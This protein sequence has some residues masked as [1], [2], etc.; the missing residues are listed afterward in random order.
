M[1]PVGQD[2]DEITIQPTILI[3]ESCQNT[4]RHL[5]KYSRKDLQ[6]EDGDVKDKVKPRKSIKTFAISRG[7]SV[8]Q[9]RATSN[10]R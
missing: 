2:R 3:H 5:S 7:I 9:S 4:I 1:A 6:T 10:V 8:W